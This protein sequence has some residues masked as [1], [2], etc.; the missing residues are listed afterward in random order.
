MF[1][2]MHRCSVLYSISRL[3]ATVLTNTTKIIAHYRTFRQGK[4]AKLLAQIN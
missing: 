3:H 4:N 2:E 1:E